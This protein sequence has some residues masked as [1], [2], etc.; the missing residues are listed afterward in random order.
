MPVPG[1]ED[2]G[3]HRCARCLES[4]PSFRKARAIAA[5]EAH[6]EAENSV[7][8]SMIRRYKYGPNQS[9][10]CAIAECL[11]NDLPVYADDYDLV[12]PVPL[13][14]SRLRWRG[15]NQAALLAAPVARRLG[16]KLD[17]G[18]LIRVV[19][20]TPQTAKDI[21]TRRRNVRNAFAVK[22]PARIANRRVLLIDDV[23]TTGATANEC[24]RALRAAGARSVDVLT[25]AR[26]L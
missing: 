17:V 20:T 23:M 2:G 3:G 8:A 18:S 10:G 24:A 13:H 12:I 15:F 4:P 7:L 26:V 11:G 25:L 16:C 21:Q 19:P 9:M 5:Y 22:R 14:P 6:A 1:F